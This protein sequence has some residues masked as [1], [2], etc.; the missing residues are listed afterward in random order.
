MKAAFDTNILID[1]F[2][3]YEHAADELARYKIKVISIISVIEILVGATTRE[4]DRALRT[5]LSS[6]E[7]RELSHAITEA[8]VTLRRAHKLKIPDAIVY[9]T[10][11][12]EGCPLVTRN[13]KDLKPDWPDIRIPYEV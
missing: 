5:F 10:A 6:F 2:N 8:T 13:K 4:E 9:A 7:V 11:R 12:V 3:G 1:Y